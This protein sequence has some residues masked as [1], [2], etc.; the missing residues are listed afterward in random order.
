MKTLYNSILGNTS[1]KVRQT[2]S[3]MGS[4]GMVHPITDIRLY[5]YAI[6]T[7][8]MH[9]DKDELR[10]ETKGK[11]FIGKYVEDYIKYYIKMDNDYYNEYKDEAEKLTMFFIW[12]DNLDIEGAES[13][14]DIENIMNT[15]LKKVVANADKLSI[16]CRGNT[17]SIWWYSI[18]VGKKMEGVVFGIKSD[19]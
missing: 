4:I 19:V 16:K 1:Q 10:K 8:S 6:S 5:P 7:L 12:L 2:K 13:A 15:E 9:L 14:K 17:S 18:Y 3:I 11:D